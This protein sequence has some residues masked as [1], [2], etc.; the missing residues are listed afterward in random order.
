[1]AKA[2]RRDGWSD[3]TDSVGSVGGLDKSTGR[4]AGAIHNVHPPKNF[5]GSVTAGI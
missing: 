3:R 2:A 4:S 1:V 5:G